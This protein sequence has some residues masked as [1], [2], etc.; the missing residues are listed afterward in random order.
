VIDTS[1]LLSKRSMLGAASLSKL[2]CIAPACGTA[3]RRALEA[4]V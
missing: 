1:E 3:I 2:S 4:V